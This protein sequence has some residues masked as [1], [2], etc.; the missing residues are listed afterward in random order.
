MMSWYGVMKELVF[1]KFRKKSLRAIS[2]ARYDAVIFM[3]TYLEIGK[4]NT[5]KGFTINSLKKVCTVGPHDSDFLSSL[6]VGL[7]IQMT[8][9]NKSIILLQTTNANISARW[10]YV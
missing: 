4:K 8:G 1:L 7:R 6:N 10:E 9:S 3:T 5:L 2:S